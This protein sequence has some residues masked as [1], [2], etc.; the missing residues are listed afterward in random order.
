MNP[1]DNTNANGYDPTGASGTPNFETYDPVPEAAT[2]GYPNQAGGYADPNQAYAAPGQAYADPNQAYVDPSQTYTDPNQAYVDPSQAY[3]DSNQAYTDPNQAYADPN[4]AYANPNQAYAGTPADPAYG[5][6]QPTDPNATGFNGYTSAN[7]AN[8]TPSEKAKAKKKSGKKV[9]PLT[10]GLIVVVVIAIVAVALIFLWPTL[11]PE[12]KSTPTPNPVD[13]EDDGGD[14]EEDNGKTSGKTDTGSDLSDADTIL[15]CTLNSTPETLAAI[16]NASSATQELVAAYKNE[17][18]SSISS[19]V[20]AVYPDALQAFGGFDAI[21][22]A[23]NSNVIA[24]GLPTDPFT[25]TYRIAGN[26]VSVTHEATA[27]ELT[28]QSAPL[29]ALG[30]SGDGAVD[31]SLKTIT[32]LYKSASYTCSQEDQS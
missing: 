11:F 31:T 6:A 8:P 18:L 10:I 25:S 7:I 23:W 19:T 4:Q 16:G 29:M 17:K 9:S 3:A 21:R 13:Y 20:S 5:S 2:G 24:N 1:E 22:S 32:D 15:T 30:G 26:K 14:D 12:N 27:A 28:S